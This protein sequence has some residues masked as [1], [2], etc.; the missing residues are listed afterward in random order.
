MARMNDMNEAPQTR[1]MKYVDKN[2]VRQTLSP[3]A[4]ARLAHVAEHAPVGRLTTPDQWKAKDIRSLEDRGLWNVTWV[5]LN[6]EQRVGSWIITGL[7]EIGRVV[8]A[9]WR[10]REENG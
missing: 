8:L 9:A 7:T 2:G 5:D 10:R 4:A 1:T 3:L 6:D